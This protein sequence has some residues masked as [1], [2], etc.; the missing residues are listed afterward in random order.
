[1]TPRIA[2]AALALAVFANGIA[3]AGALTIAKAGTGAGTVVSAEFD[4]KCGPVCIKEVGTYFVRLTVVP[5]VGS[6]FG[7]WGGHPDC[8][9]G[10]VTMIPAGI[11]CVATFA[12]VAPPGPPVGGVTGV[13]GVAVARRPVGAPYFRAFGPFDRGLEADVDRL[14]NGHLSGSSTGLP[15]APAITEPPT[16]WPLPLSPG[17]TP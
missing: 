12:L 15:P 9:D 8:D 1:M 4:I 3:D 6:V 2:V 11:T 17:A 16:G 5:D 10:S 13:L 7:G 14:R